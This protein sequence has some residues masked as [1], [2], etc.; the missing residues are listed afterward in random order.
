L[1]SIAKKLNILRRGSPSLFREGRIPEASPGCKHAEDHASKSQVAGG[2]EEI[3]AERAAAGD[4]EA[5]EA[6]LTT[7][8]PWALQLARDRMTGHRGHI[9]AEDVVQDSLLGLWRSISAYQPGKP[10]RAWVRVM[11]LN[12]TRS[13]WRHAARQSE[14][15]GA[16]AQNAPRNTEIEIDAHM[17]LA[18]V[19][20]AIDDLS[21]SLRD[22]ILKLFDGRHDDLNPSTLRG[23]VR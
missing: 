4:D 21:P 20:A 8:R 6:L 15:L 14:R 12:R 7:L 18:R 2:A 13:V 22:A 5:M 17:R 19:Q 9:T 10:V 1:S 3:L 23:R 11:I 16:L